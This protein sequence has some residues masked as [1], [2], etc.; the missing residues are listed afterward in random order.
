MRDPENIP[1]TLEDFMQIYED[2]EK[3]FK[4]KHSDERE[5]T[6]DY[7]QYSTYLQNPVTQ[8]HQEYFHTKH[9][10]KYTWTPYMYLLFSMILVILYLIGN[11]LSQSNSP[12]N[13]SGRI[14]SLIAVFLIAFLAPFYLIKLTNK[15]NWKYLL[16]SLVFVIGV[17]YTILVIL[18]FF[19]V[20]ESDS[21]M[22]DKLLLIVGV[23]WAPTSFSI[24]ILLK[25]KPYITD[26]GGIHLFLGW[27]YR[28]SEMKGDIK[29]LNASFDKLLIELDNWLNHV[30]KLV[31]KNKDEILEGFYFNVLSNKTF[32]SDIE[33]DHRDL[34]E[35]IL[36]G[37]LV[38]DL[39]HS[40]TFSNVKEEE[41]TIAK[42]KHFDLA[43]LNYQLAL[44]EFPN[45]IKLI[46]K[47]TTKNLI[48][49]YYS[50]VKKLKK[51]KKKLISVIAY[52][53]T[54]L[55]APILSL[56]FNSV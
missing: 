37:L 31:I 50:P 29:A 33:E 10:G 21:V 44:K 24:F 25:Y 14:F 49:D 16:Y 5:I 32:L 12:D 7:L 4:N 56:F 34:F 3:D 15:W 1:K 9:S 26:F 52:I 47:I 13:L 6:V 38:E 40:E 55:F 46:E 30:F 28:V 27:I 54:T 17:F 51:L 48:I 20:V 11:I 23:A 53:I 43:W 19:S 22:L 39:V 42:L 45:I 35:K 41:K 8:F 36:K 2:Y 18:S